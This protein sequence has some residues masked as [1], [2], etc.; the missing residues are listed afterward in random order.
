MKGGRRRPTTS[1]SPG[2][3]VVWCSF[4]DQRD[5]HALEGL[6]GVAVCCCGVDNVYYVGVL[7]PTRTSVQQQQVVGRFVSAETYHGAARC[8]RGLRC[9]AYFPNSRTIV[10]WRC[11]CG[12]GKT[13]RRVR[14][15]AIKVDNLSPLWCALFCRRWRVLTTPPQEVLSPWYTRAISPF[16]ILGVCPSIERGGWALWNDEKCTFR[17]FVD[18]CYRLQNA[19]A[20][21]GARLRWSLAREPNRGWR[22]FFS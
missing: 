4:R 13:P 1:S 3:L 8:G 20:W 7:P 22:E 5:V 9:R 11:R 15:P 6:H 14:L 10:Y 17:G 19:Q 16:S 12:R 18:T 2:S 21:R